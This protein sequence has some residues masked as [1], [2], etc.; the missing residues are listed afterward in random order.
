MQWNPLEGE[1]ISEKTPFYVKGKVNA[2]NTRGKILVQT[3]SRPGMLNFKRVFREEVLCSFLVSNPKSNEFSSTQVMDEIISFTVDAGAQFIGTNLGDANDGLYPVFAGKIHDAGLKANIYS[4]NTLEQMEKYYGPGKGRK[5][6][7]LADGM[8]TNR[9]ELTIDFYHE[10]K[11][12]K[13]GTTGTPA[14]IL[15]ELG[16]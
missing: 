12:R 1:K 15:E 16:Y 8:I 11:A 13:Y 3:F 9:A 14:G 7:P 10:R 6:D 5:A 2:G 4:I